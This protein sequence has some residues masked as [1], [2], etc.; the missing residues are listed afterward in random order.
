MA[1]K[2]LGHMGVKAGDLFKITHEV[3]GEALPAI[4]GVVVSWSETF[5]TGTAKITDGNAAGAV[6]ELAAFP[7]GL[8]VLDGNSAH[9]V[10]IIKRKV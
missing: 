7:G 8:K 3:W 4:H 1:D 5:C 2:G 10:V 6:V 9:S